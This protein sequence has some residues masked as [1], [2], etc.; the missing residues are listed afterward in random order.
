ML[1]A[2]EELNHA[3]DYFCDSFDHVGT[4]IGHFVHAGW[5]RSYP[6]GHCPGGASGQ[7]GSGT[8]NL[9]AVPAF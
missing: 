6:I 3:L 8:K 5:I 2:G 1:T 7:F 4:G 9:G